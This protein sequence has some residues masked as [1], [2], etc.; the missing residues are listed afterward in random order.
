[1][2]LEP[3]SIHNHQL[4]KETKGESHA[5]P[6]KLKS[7]EKCDIPMRHPTQTLQPRGKHMPAPTS[8]QATQPAVPQLYHARSLTMA[9]MNSE[10]NINQTTL[11]LC[12]LTRN[13]NPKFITD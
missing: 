11:F 5:L 9:D 12:P 10:N 7:L 6:D 1:M 4:S 2:R 8:K 3:L 13:M